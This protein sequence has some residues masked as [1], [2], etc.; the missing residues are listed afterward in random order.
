MNFE[1]ILVTK[2]DLHVLIIV[3]HKDRPEIKETRI[4]CKNENEKLTQI[5]TIN[6]QMIEKH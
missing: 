5:V 3:F 1:K 4:L 6:Q 2:Y